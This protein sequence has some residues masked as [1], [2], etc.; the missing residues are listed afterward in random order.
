M[1]DIFIGGCMREV[2]DKAG[3][4]GARLRL[5]GVVGLYWHACLWKA[6]L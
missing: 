5:S 3:N 2:K 4:V 6:A 1:F